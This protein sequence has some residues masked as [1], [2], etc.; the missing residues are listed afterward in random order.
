MNTSEADYNDIIKASID[1]KPEVVKFGK[2]N[3]GKGA[4]S[5]H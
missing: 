4:R 3:V 5:P 2:P 1:V